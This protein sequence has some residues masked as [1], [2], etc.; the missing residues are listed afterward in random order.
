MYNIPK[1]TVRTGP[2]FTKATSAEGVRQ[3]LAWLKTHAKE[4]QGQ[5]I[6]LNEGIFLGADESF[7]KLRRMLKEVDQL[8]IALF[9]N[10]K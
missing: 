10:L 8:R 7:V 2:T 3:N 6:A 4:Y 5:W 1:P 9:I